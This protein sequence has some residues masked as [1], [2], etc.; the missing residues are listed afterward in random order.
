MIAHRQMLPQQRQSKREHRPVQIISFGILLLTTMMVYRQDY[1]KLSVFSNWY[2]DDTEAAQHPN[3]ASTNTTLSMT[4][5]GQYTLPPSQQ[6]NSPSPVAWPN[7]LV[8]YSGPASLTEGDPD[9]IQFYLRN[10]EFFLQ[11]GIDCRSQETIIVLGHDVALLYQ[12]TIQQLDKSCYSHHRVTLI[13]RDNVCYDMES[14]R[15]V[16]H[17]NVTNLPILDYDYFFHVN[18]GTTGPVMP[19]NETHVP[20]T[21]KFIEKLV[22]NI[23]MVGI[24]HVCE[25]VMSHI[26]SMVYA[27]DKVGLQLIQK[28][29]CVY[30]CRPFIDALNNV[31]ESA[32]VGSIINQYERGM[33]REILEQGY[34]IASLYR[35]K[36]LTKENQGNCTDKDMWLTTHLN[37]ALGKIPS[38]GE[39]MFFK[40]SR[41][42]TKET[43]RLINFTGNIW[44]NW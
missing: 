40:T 24:S 3:V 42:L 44:W 32:V 43:A 8:V 16:M 13:E 9:K 12:E 34:A 5:P 37:E 27:L 35:P 31:S 15:L 14:V 23:K 20:W 7:I 10:L 1:S 18:C 29:S 41:I 25:R 19:L 28:S 38:L 17:G 39:V 33:G 4:L 6:Q 36:T 11:H 26:Q 21:S 30:D 2:W 22:G